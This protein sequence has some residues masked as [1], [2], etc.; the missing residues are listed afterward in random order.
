MMYASSKVN[1]NV[2]LGKLKSN[3]AEM[4]ASCLTILRKSV[5][6]Y[7][8]NSVFYLL[9]HEKLISICCLFKRHNLELRVAAV[10]ILVI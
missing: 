7:V 3:C 10:A 9:S 8:K 4:I 6:K 1:L 5:F 2:K